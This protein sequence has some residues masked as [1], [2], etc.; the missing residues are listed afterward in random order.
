MIA[1][2]FKPRRK[3]RLIPSRRADIVDIA[4]LIGRIIAGGY[5]ILGAFNHF[6]KLRMM[7][8]YAKSKGTPAPELAVGGTGVLLLVGGLSLVLGYQPTVGLAILIVFLLGVSFNIHNFWTVQDPQMKMG[9]MV[10]F[11][12]NMGLIGLLLMLLAIPQPWPISLGR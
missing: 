7:A 10:N 6:A 2:V 3:F 5:F 8:S 4:F 1:A 12:K 11:M 9:E